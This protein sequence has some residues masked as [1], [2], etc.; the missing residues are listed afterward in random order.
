[1]ETDFTLRIVNVST[2]IFTEQL[3]MLF[4][5]LNLL[6]RITKRARMQKYSGPFLQKRPIKE[7]ET[8]LM[9]LV[10]LNIFSEAFGKKID[11]EEVTHIYHW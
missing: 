9:Y 3:G 1:M 11:P 7:F 8:F 4:S 5:N 2:L 6:N 10:G